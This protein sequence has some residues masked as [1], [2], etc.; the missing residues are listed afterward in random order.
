VVDRKFEKTNKKQTTRGRGG[1]GGGGVLKHGSQ[2]LQS[3]QVLNL[4]YFE[5]FCQ[6]GGEV[7]LNWNCHCF[8]TFF[9]SKLLLYQ[10]TFFFNNNEIKT[11]KEI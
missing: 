9:Y 5:T 1:G 2:L 11:T 8:V 10:A 7:P 3:F 4:E 6:K